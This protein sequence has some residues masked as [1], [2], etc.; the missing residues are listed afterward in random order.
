M[1]TIVSAIMVSAAILAHAAITVGYMEVKW[2]D[3]LKLSK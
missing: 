3:L 1:A 2:E